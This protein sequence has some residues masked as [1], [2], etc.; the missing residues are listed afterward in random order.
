MGNLFEGDSDT[1]GDLNVVEI[2]MKWP[3]IVFIIISVVIFTP[4]AIV[5]NYQYYKL[6]KSYMYKRRRPELVILF[7]CIATMFIG[8]YT[9]IH[10]IVFEIYWDNNATYEEYWE[11]AFY[12]TMQIFVFVTFALRTWHSFFDF[13]LA[14]ANSTGQWKSILNKSYTGKTKRFFNKHKNSLGI[15]FYILLCS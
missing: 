2:S 5:M 4:I 3:Y 8:I 10:I 9:P 15:I 6:R 7:N 1:E 13:K 12:F 14:H 11:Q